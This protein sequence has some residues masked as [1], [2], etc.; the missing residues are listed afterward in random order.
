MSAS[1][2]DVLEVLNYLCMFVCLREFYFD[3]E[4]VGNLDELVILSHI[5]VYVMLSFTS[6]EL[7]SN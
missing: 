6:S 1:I 2:C 3:C 7:I 5:V 4:D